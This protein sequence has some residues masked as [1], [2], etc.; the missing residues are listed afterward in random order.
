MMTTTGIFVQISRA[1]AMLTGLEIGYYKCCSF[2]TLWNPIARTE[3]YLHKDWLIRDEIEQKRHK[4]YKTQVKSDSILLP[5]LN[6]NLG[7]FK[8]FVKGLEKES[9]DLHILHRSSLL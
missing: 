4:M 2:L 5:P 9:P 8:Q 7:L 6:I 1:V 3:H